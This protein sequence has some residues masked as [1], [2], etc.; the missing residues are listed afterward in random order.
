MTQ[1]TDGRPQSAAGV[2][3]SLHRAVDAHDLDGIVAHFA[4]DYALD[5]PV[6]PDRSF[7]GAEQVRRNWSVL[8]DSMPD[9][10]LEE[11]GLIAQGS[12]VWTEIAIRG[13]LR[14]GDEQVLRGVMIFRVTAGLISAATFYLS[15][16]V[17][18]GLDADAAVHAV[19][20]GSRR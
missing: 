19:A 11:R 13:R 14:D 5:D 1:Q 20:E 3:Q 12:T 17:R 9:L 10:A 6:H 2:V 8:L 7:R 15:P 18:D 4:H 16:V